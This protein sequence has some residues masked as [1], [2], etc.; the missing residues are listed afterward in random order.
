MRGCYSAGDGKREM[1]KDNLS[2]YERE[3]RHRAVTIVGVPVELGSDERGL[4]DAPRCMLEGGL[5][6]IIAGLGAEVSGVKM[7]PCPKPAGV[8]VGSAKYLDEIAAIS[9][10]SALV[11]AEAV[12]R[13]QMI[14]ALGGDH[15]MAIGTIAGAAQAVPRLGV[16]WIDAHPDINTHETTETGNIHGMAAAAAMGFGHPQLVNA[17][18][19]G[20]KISPP[21]FLYIGLKDID[22][23]EIEMLR[24]HSIK[25]ITMLDIAERGLS[26][27]MLAIESLRRN[28]D[29]IWVSMDLDSVDEEYAPG[30]GLATSG[31]LTRREAAVL[32]QYIGKRCDLVGMDIVEMSPHKDVERKTLHLAYELIARLLGSEYSWYRDY[33]DAYRAGSMAAE[34]PQ[35][36]QK[37]KGH[38][39]M[40]IT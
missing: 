35:D 34:R 20:Q 6:K 9:N 19:A 10:A 8:A 27:A 4:A 26:H 22:A 1:E 24:R 31:G 38:A 36:L 15:S 2:F 23:A 25:T 3:N 13:A 17:G 12:K 7:I 29:A 11:V 30:V 5:E 33:M 14:V 39:S 40:A 32:A 37:I 16:I 21:D 18:R 28:V